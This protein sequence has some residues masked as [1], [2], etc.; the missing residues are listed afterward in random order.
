MV[1][2]DTVYQRVLTLANKEQRGYITPQDFNLYANQAQMEIFE[3][4]FYDLNQANREVGNDTTYADV[5]DMLDEKLQIFEREDISPSYTV[6]SGNLGGGQQ[7][8]EW[9]YRVIR[10][11]AN[12]K[13]CEILSTKDFQDTRN[14]SYLIKPTYERPVVN[15]KNNV[16][17]ILPS[18]SSVS[19]VSYYTKPNKVSWGYFVLNAKALYDSALTV[20]FELHPSEETELVY[21]ILKLAGAGMKRDDVMKIGQ[22]LESV[23]V[24]QEKQ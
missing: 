16:I 20:N 14:A 21:K 1:L 6:L 7:L 4:Y 18:T 24:Q 2:I 17:R 13:D 8:P 15:I 23:Q 12:D 9:I 10:I 19:S 3:Q 11:E 5:D 22:G